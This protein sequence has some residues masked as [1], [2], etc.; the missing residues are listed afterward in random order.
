M[1]VS[2]LKNLLTDLVNE[3]DTTI[4]SALNNLVSYISANQSAEILTTLKQIN[5]HFTSS[6]VNNYTPSNLKILEEIGGLEFFGNQAYIELEKILNKNSYNVQKIISDLQLYLK[7]R[8]EFL[9]LI[10]ET[11]DNLDKLNIENHYNSDATFEVGLLLPTEYTESKIIKI[12]KE[13]NH[14]DKVFKTLKELVGES[15]TDTEINFVSNGSLQ[16]F[17]DNSQTIGVCIAVGI[18]RIT[19]LYK[20][21]IEIRIAK[22]KLKSLGVNS[23]DQKSI[24]KS[25]KDFFN[26]EIE[27][28]SADLIKEF[29]VKNIEN[30]RLNE[31]KI[32]MKGH[33]TYIAKCIDNGITIEVIPPE[34]S[35]PKIKETEE[36]K[37]EVKT[38]KD[39]YDKTLKQIEIVQKSMETI[40]TIGNTG[41]DIAKFLT[42]NEDEPKT[43]ETDTAE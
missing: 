19:K 12:T 32:A 3:E 31:L 43:E 9:E 8:N 42:D 27:K 37:A 22:E 29:A 36:N 24:D 28:I 20:N 13:L 38:V 4:T 33:V 35:E 5:S 23:G 7:R 41:I 10:N 25:E 16:F 34:L 26:K 40:K 11:E 15:P 21:I 17:I 14:W 39:N 18:E 1:D 30:G 6:L 2:K